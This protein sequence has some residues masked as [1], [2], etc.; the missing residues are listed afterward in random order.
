MPSAHN[1][2]IVD[3]RKKVDS[4]NICTECI[5]KPCRSKTLQALNASPPE[6]VNH[7]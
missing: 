1:L 3:F 2:L 5:K 7:F 6:L 4:Q